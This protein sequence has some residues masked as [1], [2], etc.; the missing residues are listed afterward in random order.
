MKSKKAWQCLTPGCGHARNGGEWCDACER[1]YR[2]PKVQVVQVIQ[3]KVYPT[4]ASRYLDGRDEM[5]Y[6]DGAQRWWA[7]ARE[8]V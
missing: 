8:V 7:V 5:E 2:T 1:R 6:T 4:G 3:T